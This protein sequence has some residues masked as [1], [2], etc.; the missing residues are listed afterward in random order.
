MQ[1][2]ISALI[3][4]LASLCI[5]GC[6]TDS[7]RLE[8]ARASVVI[9]VLGDAT[10]AAVITELSKHDIRSVETLA[11]QADSSLIVVV[12]DS[13]VGPMPVHL[14]IA[15]ALQKRPAEEYV[16]VFTKTALVDDQEL[17]ELEELEC[18]EI[19]NSQG[20]PGDYILFGFDSLTAPVRSDYDCPR[21]WEAIA[22]HIKKMAR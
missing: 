9:T 12:Q 4:P 17:L 11:Q 3:A 2:P 8:P 19:F 5:L 18:R 6:N 16:W 1:L 13:T 7:P 14:E 22:S 10:A 15:K 20:L 21:G